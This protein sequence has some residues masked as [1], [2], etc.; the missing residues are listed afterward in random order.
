MKTWLIGSG[1]DCD[2]VVNAATVSGHHCRLTREAD[3]YYLED[4]A[5]SNGTFVNGRQIVARTRVARGDAIRLGLTVLL[6]WPSEAQAADVPRADGVI[7][8]GREADN[9]VVLDVPVVSGHHARIVRGEGGDLVIEDLGS[10]NGT[11]LGSPERKVMRAALSAGDTVYFGSYPVPASRLL[12]GMAPAG[13]ILTLRGESMVVG[14]DGGCDQVIDAPM[15]SGRHARLTRKG[16]TVWVEDL[17]SANGTFVNGRRIDRP[18]PVSAGDRIGLG[19][20]TLGLAIAPPAVPEAPAVALASA[21]AGAPSP[22]ADDAG[23]VRYL[24]V[25]A[26]PAQALVI[27]AAIVVAFRAKAAAPATAAT[28]AESSHAV[29]AA[30][31]WLGLAAVWVGLCHPLVE[32]AAVWVLR[33]GGSDRP[34][35]AGL[36]TRIA[37]YSLLGALQ[38]VLLLAVV[39]I[40]LGLKGPKLPMLGVLALTSAVGVALGSLAVSL[41]VRPAPVLAGLA[42]LV[43]AAWGLGG[44]QLPLPA[45]NPVVRAGASFLPAR[46]AFEG[47]L[48][49]EAPG[50]PTREQAGPA[51]AANGFYDLAEDYFP[52][53]SERMGVAAVMT[54]LGAMLVGLAAA[55]VVIAGWRGAR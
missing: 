3:G 37:L 8:I 36:A 50:R 1:P 30:L 54:A 9:D 41:P 23:W 43:V 4:L 52:A 12:A 19:S 20:Y 24:G 46:W 47:L 42:L 25:A 51:P 5:S 11:A 10:A 35:A 29:A 53:E 31:F 17:G 38:C 2:V 40:G 14:R 7:R 27:G 39:H 16:A 32:A 18:T 21:T 28:W 26:L 13:A 15:V 48:L 22:P 45:M 44:E 55:A 49:L 6:P 33:Q 34:E